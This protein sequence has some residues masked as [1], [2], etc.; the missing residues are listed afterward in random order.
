MAKT[1][2]QNGF[3]L[4]SLV[5]AAVIIAI[6]VMYYLKPKNGDKNVIQTGQDAEKSLRQSKD[7]L[8]NY[9]TDLNQEQQNIDAQNELNGIQ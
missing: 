3:V 1:K 2:K 4:I 7:K 5:L 9:Q 6:L 8:Q